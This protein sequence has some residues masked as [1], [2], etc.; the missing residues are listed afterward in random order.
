MTPQPENKSATNKR[1]PLFVLGVLLCPLG[2]GLAGAFIARQILEAGAGHTYYEF[3]AAGAAI[4]VI[5]I[6]IVWNF[7]RKNQ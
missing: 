6:A 1:S 2:G 4:A 7:R 3:I 5:G